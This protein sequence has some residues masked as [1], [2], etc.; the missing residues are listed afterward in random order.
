MSITQVRLESAEFTCEQL[1]G[2]LLASMGNEANDLRTVDLFAQTT[3]DA[4]DVVMKLGETRNDRPSS[5]GWLRR[6]TLAFPSQ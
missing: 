6:V 4:G 5:L 1:G 2:L 3:D